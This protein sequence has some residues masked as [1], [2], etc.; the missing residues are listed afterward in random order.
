MLR[1]CRQGGGGSLATEGE[2]KGEKGL[3]EE[4]G[5]VSF[6]G[7]MLGKMLQEVMVCSS[8]CLP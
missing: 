6:L 8:V 5:G 1:R 3:R 4:A 2:G 7:K